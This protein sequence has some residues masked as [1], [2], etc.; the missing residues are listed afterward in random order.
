MAS[1]SWTRTQTSMGPGFTQTGI[2]VCMRLSGGARLR[3]KL[4]FVCSEHPR[5]SYIH[6]PV[7][8]HTHRQSSVYILATRSPYASS[9][10][11]HTDTPC[12][13]QDS[14]NRNPH[15]LGTA[16]PSAPK[17]EANSSLM[18]V[19]CRQ[20]AIL[21]FGQRGSRWQPGRCLRFHHFWR[22]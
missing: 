14:C 17:P 22:V 3:W 21:F 1:A 10:A 16:N 4:C 2:L 9:T 5:S 13:D 19:P 7:R 11:T 20:M 15:T 12:Q 18:L 8:R 6:G